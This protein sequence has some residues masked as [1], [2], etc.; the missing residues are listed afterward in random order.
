[1]GGQWICRL[2][3]RSKL[4]NNELRRL[5]LIQFVIVTIKSLPMKGKPASAWLEKD[6]AP[7]VVGAQDPDRSG[8][9]QRSLQ[10]KFEV[11]AVGHDRPNSCHTVDF[12]ATFAL[13]FRIKRYRPRLEIDG[14][15]GDND[16]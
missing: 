13:H 16:G 8:N 3:W 11:F 5:T 7:T 9:T 6:H 1:M 10:E 12:G 15:R 2:A 4:F 14:G